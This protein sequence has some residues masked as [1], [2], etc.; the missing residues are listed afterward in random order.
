MRVESL[1]LCTRQSTD[2]WSASHTS[3]VLCLPY[4]SNAVLVWFVLVSLRL[5]GHLLPQQ[6]FPTRGVVLHELCKLVTRQARRRFGQN[7][8]VTRVA[9]ARRCQLQVLNRETTYSRQK[10]GKLQ[11]TR[12]KTKKRKAMGAL[13][14]RRYHA[15]ASLLAPSQKKKRKELRLGANIAHYDTYPST[16]G[17]SLSSI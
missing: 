5:L 16:S 13:G 17:R 14:L 8:G 4:N 2:T 7:V 9:S 6:A 3:V 10:R 11:D 15:W 1:S 12:E